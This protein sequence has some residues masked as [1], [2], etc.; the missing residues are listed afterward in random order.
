M[1][2][3]SQSAMESLKCIITFFFYLHIKQCIKSYQNLSN[4]DRWSGSISTIEII[5]NNTSKNVFIFTSVHFIYI[6]TFY[7]HIYLH[8]NYSLLLHKFHCR[9]KKTKDLNL[10]LDVWSNKRSLTQDPTYPGSILG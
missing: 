7:L 3:S 2:R 10:I 1:S 9:A 4:L 6:F 8:F 5:S